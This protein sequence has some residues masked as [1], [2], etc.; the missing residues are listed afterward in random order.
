M[1]ENQKL[2]S[3]KKKQ[4]EEVLK[5]KKEIELNREKAQTTVDTSQH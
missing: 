4:D 5:L 3:D 1:N 2:V